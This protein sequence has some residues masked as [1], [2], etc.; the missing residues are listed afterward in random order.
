M[1][2]SKRNTEFSLVKCPLVEVR[3]VSA[4]LIGTNSVFPSRCK[5]LL[6]HFPVHT[7]SKTPGV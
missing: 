1:S 3:Y 5:T 6:A 2:A 4:K 7:G